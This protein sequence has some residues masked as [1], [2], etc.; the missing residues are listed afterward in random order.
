MGKFLQ[1]QLL[2]ATKRHKK[3]QKQA[4]Q[5]FEFSSHIIPRR[6]ASPCSFCGFSRLLVAILFTLSKF[7]LVS[8]R[9]E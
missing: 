7:L 2:I 5:R 8:T 6:D 1:A 3:A 4:V 9:S